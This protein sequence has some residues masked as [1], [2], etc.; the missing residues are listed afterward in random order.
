MLRILGQTITILA[1][2]VALPASAH[3]SNVIFD[4]DTEIT[5]RGAVTR[6]IWR[7]PHVYLY[8]ETPNE[9]GGTSEWQIE[10]DPTPIMARSFDI[11]AS[12]SA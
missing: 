7:N 3:H 9:A 11:V 5:I 6:Y 10:A 1:V 2:T 12:S 8:V 4:R